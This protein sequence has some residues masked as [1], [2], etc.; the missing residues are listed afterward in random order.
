MSTSNPNPFEEKNTR[1]VARLKGHPGKQDKP[2]TK[3]ESPISK[4]KPFADSENYCC[5]PNEKSNSIYL[6][7]APISGKFLNQ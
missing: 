5:V 7:E 6:S 3:S 4:R 2:K 1:F